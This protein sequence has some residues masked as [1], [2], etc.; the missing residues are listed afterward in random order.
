MKKTQKMLA[1]VL[2]LALVLTALFT[3]AAC[4]YNCEKNGHKFEEGKCTECGAI[5][6]DYVDHVNDHAYGV[7]GRCSCGAV[8]PTAAYTMHDYISVTP[9]T[10]NELDSTDANDSAVMG[11]IGSA[12]FEY[13]FEF[14]G[15]KFNSDGTVNAD[16]IVDGGFTVKYAAA[17][18]LEDVTAEYA[19][20]WGL[21]AKQVEEGGYAWKITLRDDLKWDDG[22]AIKAEDFVYSM[23]EQ[24]NP[25]FNNGRA[26]SYYANAVQIRN[27][28][29]YFY[30]GR[31]GWFDNAK[32]YTRDD[33]VKGE[34]GT[35]TLA[36]RPVV[37]VLN[38]YLSWLG[39]SLNQV[40][41]AYDGEYFDK[42]D[43][44]PLTALADASGRVQ[45]T[46][47]SLAALEQLIT[48]KADWGETEA[49]VVQY[50]YYF[51]T[52]PEVDFEDVGI[53][54]ASDYDIVLVVDNPLYMFKED[55]KTLSYN[56]AYSFSGLPLVKRDLYEKCKVAPSDP[57]GIWTSTYNTT[58]ETSASWGPYKLTSFQA[59]KQFVLER[60]EHWY[61]YKVEE[62]KGLY[63][64]TKIVTEVIKTEE[65]AQM[66]FW[67][68]EIDGLG[69]SVTIADDYKNSSYA[70]FSPRTAVFGIQVYS[71]IDVLKIS[72]RNN[73]ILAIKEFRQA[74]S[75]SLDRTAYARDLSTANQPELGLLSADYYYDVE[76]GGVYRY[77]TQAQKA[78]LRT[79][80]Y[81]ENANGTWTD[82]VNTF[83]T[84]EDA[85]DSMTGVNRELAKQK[86]N[87]A[88]DILMADP[89]AYGYDPN[90][91]IQIMYG[92]TDESESA[93]RYYNWIKNWI[94][95]LVE[96]TKLEG[97][98]EVVSDFTLG[99]EWAN[100]F[101]AGEYDLSTSGVGN[102]PFDPFYFIGAQINMA[103]SV[104]YHT[105]W[106]VDKEEV[107][108][109]LPV[110]EDADYAG[111]GQELT[112]TVADWY[113]SLNGYASAGASY[114]WKNAPVEVRLE[115]LAMLE[116]YGLQQ[117]YV[118][119]TVR[120]FT[121]SLHTAKSSYVVSSENVMMGFGGIKYMSYNYTDAEWD[122]FVASHNGDLREFYK[123]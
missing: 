28:R 58:V 23:Q 71:N 49:E 61:G 94:D 60:N 42:A 26:D 14:D 35:Y 43:L 25:Q 82:G 67:A 68:G 21:T 97:K 59:D 20:A 53:F 107:T 50:M 55:G 65:A 111:E 36:G 116:E 46:D 106:A 91:K 57:N 80:G 105:Y 40:V 73:G 93:V 3:L 77:T 37:I 9:S 83:A 84:I 16:A 38:E 123:K 8:D 70:I 115:I 100:K 41:P 87:E 72:E 17:T 118:L 103:A 2:V 104:S 45:V 117:Y 22:T 113:N 92:D 85:V 52:Y 4:K 110:V 95:D 13:D 56:A 114:N 101:K 44:E 89:E 39:A 79:Y 74:M 108:F 62:N 66:A 15:D 12:F 48:R 98:V 32:T 5:D 99:N 88:Y 63:Q 30:Q 18:A 11:Y 78:L 7:N 64:T 81:T 34:D 24:L 29:N 112:L 76:N 120:G 47:E 51:Y 122:K 10:W 27:A 102:A 31:E 121:A 96:G 54:A 33:L 6:P 1:L 75:L 19:E 90:K 109:T 119:P 86:A 69:I